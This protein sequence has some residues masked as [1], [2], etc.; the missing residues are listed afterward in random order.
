MENLE[1]EIISIIKK[2]KEPDCLS[3]VK[4]N[5][6]F[7]I[8]SKIDT[9]EKLIIL[10]N[11][12]GDN[13]K[14]NFYKKKLEIE[15]LDFFILISEIFGN[16][17]ISNL[18]KILSFIKKKINNDNL[19]YSVKLG[20][21][22][23]SVMKNSF[24]NSNFFVRNQIFTKEINYFFEKILMIDNNK[25]FMI[26]CI[27]IEMIKNVDFEIIDQNKEILILKIIKILKDKKEISNENFLNCLLKI[28]LK[29]KKKIYPFAKKLNLLIKEFIKSKNWKI[30]KICLE[31]FNVLFIIDKKNIEF[32]YKEFFQ[33]INKLKLHKNKFV[34]ESSMDSIILFKKKT[35]D[36]IL[37][38]Q[39]LLP[40]I[41][42]A[43]SQNIINKKYNYDNIKTSIDKQKLNKNFVKEKEKNKDL[44]LVKKSE[45]YEF[46][47]WNFENKNNVFEK[48]NQE[49]NFDIFENDKEYEN[50]RWNFD[51]F[52]NDNNLEKKNYNNLEK[53]KYNKTENLPYL[54]NFMNNDIE[55]IGVNKNIIF[56]SNNSPNLEMKK[57]NLNK[58]NF[59]KIEENFLKSDDYIQ[60]EKLKKKLFLNNIYLK[61]ENQKLNKKVVKLENQVLNMKK[62]IE[63]LKTSNSFIL[64]KFS[65][66]EKF[67]I[68]NLNE[69]SL[70]IKK[71]K[72]ESF[73]ENTNKF[74]YSLKI[75]KKSDDFIISADSDLIENK[76]FQENL[77]SNDSIDKKSKNSFEKIKINNKL[78]IIFSKENKGNF[79]LLFLKES[80]NLRNFSKIQQNNSIKLFKEIL[81][82][83]N[84]NINQDVL[85][86]E[87]CLRWFFKYLENEKPKNKE[88]LIQL[89]NILYL[90]S[91][92]YK[93]I[94]VKEKSKE[95]IS[96]PYF[97]QF[98]DIVDKDKQKKESKF[99]SSFFK[100]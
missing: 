30:V 20:F 29:L 9:E 83:I 27:M 99:E 33:I 40:K 91:N 69:S 61:N 66:F 5:L 94:G 24:K 7:Y 89:F 23:S 17:I 25:R 85:I 77:F 46:K 78:E 18:S 1:K 79:L 73:G 96:H 93:D 37:I 3:S 39:I 68:K 75:E 28:I 72:F 14:L 98:E 22:Y 76:N 13:K 60:K 43:R 67:F 81:L 71:D 2:I 86:I 92:T 38:K 80:E 4:R 90:I 52:L 19:N 6:Q 21:I 51:K 8:S 15:K 50:L 84:K 35:K 44:V 31:I 65:D 32:F 42:R 16:Q 58:L 47:K 11:C 64:T 70:N 41:K 48:K 57:N 97:S 59:K 45:S 53:E 74:M 56:S 54:K 49:F 88:L 55:K 82:L 34:R 87:Y 26:S 36:K 63:N 95:L 10:I 62:D 12:I 100:F